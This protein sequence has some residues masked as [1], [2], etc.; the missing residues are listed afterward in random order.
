MYGIEITVY[1][2]IEHVEPFTSFEQE[3]FQT[4]KSA[5]KEIHMKKEEKKTLL[6]HMKKDDKEFRSQ[7]KDDSE[8]KKKLIG[9]KKK[10]KGK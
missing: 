1:D 8:L 5:L 2:D 10:K 3:W 6:S 7:L 4:I 9:N